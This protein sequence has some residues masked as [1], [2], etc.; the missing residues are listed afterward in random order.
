MAI[1][2]FRK[3]RA[4][5]GRSAV[6][7]QYALVLALTRSGEVGEARELLK[8]MR[9]FAPDNIT[10]KIAEAEIDIRAGKYDAAIALLQKGLSLSLLT[11]TL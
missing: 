9:E 10:Y 7:A 11:T 8:P 4:K 5:G 1:A 6:P 2:R 3:Q